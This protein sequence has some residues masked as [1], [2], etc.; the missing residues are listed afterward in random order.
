MCDRGINPFPNKPW[1][2]RVC[3]SSLLKTLW[4]KE[5]TIHYSVLFSHAEKPGWVICFS[6][7][8]LVGNDQECRLQIIEKRIN[9]FKSSI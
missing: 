2:S 3:S 8:V 4:E 6:L 1:F 9:V 7:T 5:L